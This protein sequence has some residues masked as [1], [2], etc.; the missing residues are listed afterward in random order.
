MSL[1][2]RD[3]ER[4]GLIRRDSQPGAGRVLRARLTRKGLST[5]RRCDR[6][7]DEIEAVMFAEAD[8]AARKTLAE[9]LMACARALRP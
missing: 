1:V 3:L 9:S 5:L 7:A 6:S 8:D 4:R 2:I